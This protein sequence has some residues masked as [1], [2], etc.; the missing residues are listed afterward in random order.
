M[1]VHHA[2]GRKSARNVSDQ[3]HVRYL[4]QQHHIRVEACQDVFAGRG[5]AERRQESTVAVRFDMQQCLLPAAAGQ[6][7]GGVEQDLLDTA[8]ERGPLVHMQQLHDTA[9][10]PAARSW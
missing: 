10:R 4:V 5:L 9:L 8:V 2:N 6:A 7:V 1:V 3:V